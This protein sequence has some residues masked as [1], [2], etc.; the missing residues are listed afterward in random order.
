MPEPRTSFQVAEVA[1]L[2][3]ERLIGELGRRRP[4]DRM[5]RSQLEWLAARLREVELPAGGAALEPG[6]TADRLF[7]VREGP[8]RIEAAGEGDGRALAELGPG[9]CFPV[10]ELHLRRPVLF[11]YRAGAAVR[12]LALS[13]DDFRALQ[14]LSAPFRE[15]CE[16]RARSFLEKLRRIQQAQLTTAD[17]VM[18]PA[19]V[20]QSGP[21]EVSAR[22]RQARDVNALAGAAGEIHVCAR[23]MIDQGVASAQITRLVS[24][25]NDQVTERVVQLELDRAGLAGLDLCWMALGSEG[26]TEQ[27]LHTDQDNGLVFAPPEGTDADEVR[28]RLLPVAERINGHLE[29]C[30][31]PRC[32]GGVMAGNPEW[33]LSE[34]EWRARFESWLDVPGPEALLRA[35]IFFDLRGVY[36]S[37]PL[38]ERLQASIAA[39][40]PGRRRFLVA[41]A[42]NAV[43]TRLPLGFFGG[44]KLEDGEHAGTV[45]LKRDAI[46]AFVDGARVLALASGSTESS[47]ERRLADAAVRGA[48]DPAEAEACAEAFHYVQ[49]L[50]LRHHY[51]LAAAGRPLDNRVKPA[52]LNPIERRFLLEALRQAKRLLSKIAREYGL[53]AS[54][55]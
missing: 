16:K 52:E 55:L 25:M 46:R 41:L 18:N 1:V 47:T 44:F 42:T 50:R 35:S 9:D 37:K 32:T 49:V 24:A 4:F 13:A 40:A 27:T 36:G 20:I 48:L 45:E 8:V 26:R 22:I 39:A 33:C 6:A 12:L 51:A 54:G 34:A 21:R 29:A 5:E 53:Q 28:A 19:S 30:G 38:V 23:R 10:E 14:A 17:S 43:A 2:E 31:F 7:V 11:G 3:G 15:H